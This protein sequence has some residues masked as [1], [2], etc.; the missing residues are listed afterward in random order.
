MI[1]IALSILLFISCNSSNDIEYNIPD[2]RDFNENEIGSPIITITRKEIPLVKASSKELI[3]NSSSDA[4]LRGDVK[5][6]F[7][8]NEGLHVSQLYSD[9]ADINQKTNNL[10]AYGNVRVISDDSVKLFSNSILWDNHYKLII[11][12][13]SVMFT[14]INNDT[15]YG[16]GFESDIDLTQWKIKKPHGT[17]SEIKND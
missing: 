6:D 7:F 17:K 3:K 16:V 2:V 9:S 15:M 11:S 13:D 4:L 5:A 8:N 12:H 14:T 1:R 10:F